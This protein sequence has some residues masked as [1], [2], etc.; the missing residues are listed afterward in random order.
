MNSSFNQFG[1]GFNPY[2]AGYDYRQQQPQ[3]GYPQQGGGQGMQGMQGMQGGGMQQTPTQAQGGMLPLEESYIENILRLNRGKVATIYMT[4]EASKEW[5]SK[6]FKGVIEAAGRDHII[7]SDQKTSK[8]YLLLM[9]YLDYITF[10]EEIAY[11]YP[12]DM[13]SSPPR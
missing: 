3:F 7:L 2:G 12:Y 1:A 4:F 9:V 6:I 10:D 11:Y 5:N 13:A 8:R